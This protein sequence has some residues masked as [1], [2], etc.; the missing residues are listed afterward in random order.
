GQPLTATAF[1]DGVFRF[2]NLAPGVYSLTIESPGF[3]TQSIKGITLTAGETHTLGKLALQVGEVKESISVAAESA[4]L[5]LA[6]AERAGLVT[7]TQRNE[8]ARRGSDLGGL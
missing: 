5:Q 2:A 8:N 3:K 1:S 6:S 7:G 4:S